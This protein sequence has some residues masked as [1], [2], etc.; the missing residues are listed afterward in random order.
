MSLVAKGCQMEPGSAFTPL[1]RWNATFP[2]AETFGP[3]YGSYYLPY[4]WSTFDGVEVP[5]FPDRIQM[6]KDFAVRTGYGPPGKQVKISDKMIRGWPASDHSPRHDDHGLQT[7]GI[8]RGI[9]YIDIGWLQSGLFGDRRHSGTNAIMLVIAN[10]HPRELV[11]YEAA[12]RFAQ[13]LVA[14]YALADVDDPSVPQTEGGRPRGF[15]RDLIDAGLHVVIVPTVNPSTYNDVVL[16]QWPQ[17]PNA[18]GEW[19]RTNGNFVDINRNFPAHW[20]QGG[21]DATEVWGRGSMPDSSKFAG[22]S[23]GSEPETQAVLEITQRSV[24]D[25]LS[26]DLDFRSLIQRLPVVAV[27]LHS[28]Y[29]MVTSFT[30]YS[31]RVETGIWPTYEAWLCGATSDCLHADTPGMLAMFGNNERPSIVGTSGLAISPWGPTVDDPATPYMHGSATYNLYATSGDVVATWSDARW[32]VDPILEPRPIMSATVE[33]TAYTKGGNPFGFGTC[34]PPNRASEAIE[35]V[36]DDL[37]PLF[38]RMGEAAF[39][40]ADIP[41][42]ST[43]LQAD[44]RRAPFPETAAVVNMGIRAEAVAQA[45]TWRTQDGP[46]TPPSDDNEYCFR[47]SPC[48]PSIHTCTGPWWSSYW[49]FTSGQPQLREPLVRYWGFA[50][51]HPDP[52]SLIPQERDAMEA[53]LRLQDCEPSDTCADLSFVLIRSGGHFDLYG[54]LLPASTSPPRRIRIVRELRDTYANTWADDLVWE[55]VAAEI[56]G[57]ASWDGSGC[58]SVVEAIELRSLLDPGEKL[59]NLKAS[60]PLLNAWRKELLVGAEWMGPGNHRVCENLELRGPSS[61]EHSWTSHDFSLAYAW[62][63]YE[64]DLWRAAADSSPTTHWTNG[65]GIWLV[66]DRVDQDQSFMLPPTV[67][68]DLSSNGNYV[69]CWLTRQGVDER[70]L[71]RAREVRDSMMMQGPWARRY[72]MAYGRYSAELAR[73]A[74]AHPALRRALLAILREGL[75]VYDGQRDDYVNHAALVRLA[76]P[77]LA[78]IRSHGSGE[79][80][81]ATKL[82]LTHLPDILAERARYAPDEGGP[83]YGGTHG[84]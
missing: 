74:A 27:D 44:D 76:L 22:T 62:H 83:A 61:W 80:R 66:H 6:W 70:S 35:S 37:L 56:P 48:N 57:S 23:P 20:L 82:A 5:S 84:R 49:T 38:S 43:P 34:A 32:A 59:K 39:D 18:S 8:R 78:V 9:P 41:K 50:V 81:E 3:H 17:A 51:R 7:D 67:T 73:L 30:H 15:W 75:R 21:W 11:T 2:G 33:V 65:T 63:T 10:Q 45:K 13:R 60:V 36:V 1:H 69:D 72:V 53:R 64:F 52:T 4:D 25:L 71:V 54:L 42:G 58:A 55:F 46:C 19:W 16:H 14:Y 79:L 26:G 40:P 12:W 31:N 77:A 29:G 28:A 68:A 47:D 24:L